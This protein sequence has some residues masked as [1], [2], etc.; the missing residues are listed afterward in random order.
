MAEETVVE[1]GERSGDVRCPGN[2]NN[3]PPYATPP[4]S[5]PSTNEYRTICTRSRS[6]NVVV[7]STQNPS[8][9]VEPED[10][11]NKKVSKKAEPSDIIDVCPVCDAEV[12]EVEVGDVDDGLS[13]T[14]ASSGSTKVVSVVLVTRNIS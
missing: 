13:V 4:S 11:E 8:N 6:R 10:K 1:T 3:P 2:V 7:E 14:F 12:K 5:V 9:N